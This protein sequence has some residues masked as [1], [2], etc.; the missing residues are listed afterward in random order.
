MRMT[1]NTE[2]IGVA[3]YIV[4]S[5]ALSTEYIANLERYRATSLPT[6]GYRNVSSRDKMQEEDESCCKAFL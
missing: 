2:K 5:L 6:N 1:F 4:F 3:V